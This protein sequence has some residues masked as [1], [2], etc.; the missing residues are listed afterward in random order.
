MGTL[1]IDLW[2]RLA[3]HRAATEDRS[4]SALFEAD[5]GRARDFAIAAQGLWF[6]FSKTAIDAEARKTAAALTR[7]LVH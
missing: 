2:G 1:M 7:Q 4:I 5:P 6:D 3:A